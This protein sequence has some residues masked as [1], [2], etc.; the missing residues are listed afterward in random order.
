MRRPSHVIVRRPDPETGELVEFT[1]GA[2]HFKPSAPRPPRIR[3]PKRVSGPGACGLRWLA[4]HELREKELLY[5]LGYRLRLTR[6]ERLAIAAGSSSSVIRPIEPD[7]E[8]GDVLDVVKDLTAEVVETSWLKRRVGG[9]FE[10]DLQYR[11]RFH[12]SDQRPLLL[13]R[14]VIGSGSQ[15]VDEIGDPLL[16]TP[17]EI[18][19]ARV[20]SAYTSI[21][22]RAV[23]GSGEEVDESLHRRLHRDTSAKMAKSQARLT[24]KQ[25][26]ERLGERIDQARENGEKRKIRILERQ[27]QSLRRTAA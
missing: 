22:S 27:L 26:I 19:Q 23:D 1:V 25:K 21:P 11:T 7:W 24:R 20:D 16:P 4:V 3:T 2:R 10:N 15:P 18:E 6:S 14:G 17:S 8:T 12:L 5:W 9:P 13:R